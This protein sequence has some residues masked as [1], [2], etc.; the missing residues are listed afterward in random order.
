MDA[1]SRPIKTKEGHSD[2]LSDKKICVL[3]ID[4][5][6]STFQDAIT[7]GGMNHCHIARTVD[8]HLV[9]TVFAHPPVSIRIGTSFI[10]VATI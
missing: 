1:F 2:I 9:D 6:C 8:F 7:H 5:L 4:V 3:V 10:V